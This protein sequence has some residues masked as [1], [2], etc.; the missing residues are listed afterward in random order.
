MR[1]VVHAAFTYTYSHHIT[2]HIRCNHHYYH[3]YHYDHRGPLYYHPTLCYHTILSSYTMLSSCTMLSSY[4][5][6]LAHRCGRTPQRGWWCQRRGSTRTPH[7]QVHIITLILILIYSYI[8]TTH[9]FIYSYYSY[10]SSSCSYTIATREVQVW[11]SM[12]IDQLIDRSID[13]WGRERGD[14]IQYLTFL[15]SISSLF[16]VHV[17]RYP[18][19]AID[20]NE[21]E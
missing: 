12:L 4:L 9:K 7:L 14:S 2:S 20:C 17:T 3:Y 21:G 10:Y 1:D 16:I 8:P 18:A 19:Q 6:S 13:K 5:S 15:L 11:W